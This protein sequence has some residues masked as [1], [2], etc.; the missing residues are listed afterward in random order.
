MKDFS[1][2]ESRV[3]STEEIVKVTS[4]ES[5]PRWLRQAVRDLMRHEGYRQYAYPDPLSVLSKK[6]PVK[7]W[8]WGYRP[9]REILDD[10]Y[11]KTGVRQ[12]EK[13]G[14][15]WTVGVG[16]T[17]GVTIESTRTVE[18]AAAELE[19]SIQDHVKDLHRLYPDWEKAPDFV[20]SVLVNMIYNM[21]Y[22]RFKQFQP[23][24]NTIKAGRYVEAAG[25]LR[26][27]AW[28]KQV[29]DRA[30]EL[31]TRLERQSIAPEHKVV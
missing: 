5:K 25:R 16:Q 11:K 6:Y 22:D 29:G 15:P 12:P 7:K 26:N 4:S 10:I 19:L 18:E 30:I 14:Q 24:I 2:V 13:Y 27:T 28:H 8:G 21:G 23:T 9:A 31:E 17:H 3:I 1:D 20:S